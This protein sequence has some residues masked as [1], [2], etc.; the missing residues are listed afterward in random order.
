MDNKFKNAIAF[1]GFI[2]FV[3]VMG[4]FSS[5]E[6]EDI[7]QETEIEIDSLISQTI[8]S[9]EDKKIFVYVIGA[10]N[11]PGVVE[12][13]LDS[14][15][16]EII[17]LAGGFAENADETA[18]NLAITVTDEE[19]IIIPYK[20]ISTNQ[21]ESAKI[22]QLFTE[23]ISNTLGKININTAS[24]EEL[25][26]LSGIGQ[27]TAEKII[28]YRNENSKFERIEDIKN[29]SGIGDAK[30]NSIKDKIVVK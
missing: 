9:E 12:A 20:E 7:L 11:K 6:D 22:N 2:I 29:V 17:E 8:E 5:A 28:N 1:G 10:V 19:K 30:F 26:T 14:R 4:I 13:P 27:S 18:I 21:K 3:I 24:I 15:M 25:K 16:Y 23:T